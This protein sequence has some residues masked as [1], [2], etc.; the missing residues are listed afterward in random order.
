METCNMSILFV[1]YIQP[2]ILRNRRWFLHWIRTLRHRLEGQVWGV[3]HTWISSSLLRAF[4]D[5]LRQLRRN[6][7]L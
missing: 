3:Y 5:T 4:I 6:I 7:L 2:A 1:V